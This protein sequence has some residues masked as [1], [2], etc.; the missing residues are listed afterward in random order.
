MSR[1]SIWTISFEAWKERPILGYGQ[2]NFSYIYASKFIPEKMWM[3]ESWYDRSHDVFFDWLVA[4]GALG[5]ISY[6]ALYVVALWLMWRRKS[7]MPLRER[8]ILTGALVGYFVHN[9]FVFDNL[10][11]YILFFFLLAYIAWKTGNRGDIQSGKSVSDDQMNMLYLP[12]VALIF[13]AVLY[14]MV[15]RPFMVNRLL[16]RGLDIN[17]LIQSMPFADAV[18]VQ[19]QAFEKA[20]SLHVVGSEEAR[21]QFLQTTVR[22]SQITIPADVSVEDRQKSVQALNNLITSARKDVEASYEAHQNDV[23][24]LSIYGMFYNGINDGVSAEKV[25]TRA[26]EIAPKK[27][28]VSFDL[29]RAYLIQGKTN[30]AYALAKE[31]YDLAPAYGDAAKMYLLASVYAKKWNETK[32]YLASKNMVVPFDSDILSGL[33]STKQIT[34]AIQLLNDFKKTNPQYTTQV[35]AYI[36]ELLASPVR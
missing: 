25:L 17:R 12:V 35:D 32:A 33:V 8:A 23:R 28:L 4:A 20:I 30:E 14:T 3:L 9:I 24:M 26:H 7:E 18:A 21:E 1:L 22:M 27:Q 34:L 2:E 6:L 31:T 29:V 13:V 36:K 15:Y 11:S 5:L 19:Q 16:V 10:I